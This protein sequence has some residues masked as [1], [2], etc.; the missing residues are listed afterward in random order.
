VC[1]THH[2]LTHRPGGLAR[3]ASVVLVA[4]MLSAPKLRVP[5]FSTNSNLLDH[6]T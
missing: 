2:A 4:L 6:S 5:S 1:C 3:A